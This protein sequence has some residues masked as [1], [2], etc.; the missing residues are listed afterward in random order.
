MFVSF[1]HR[2]L[3]VSSTICNTASW[4]PLLPPGGGTSPRVSL[5]F[6]CVFA[7][8]HRAGF[9]LQSISCLLRRSPRWLSHS[10]SFLASLRARRCP[11]QYCAGL[12]HPSSACDRS[13]RYVLILHVPAIVSAHPS[14]SRRVEFTPRVPLSFVRALSRR[15]R[16]SRDQPC[17][18]ILFSRSLSTTVALFALVLRSLRAFRGTPPSI[19][20]SLF[21]RL[22]VLHVVGLGL[23]LPD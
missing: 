12:V 14:T 19:S 5:S 6:V 21:P 18:L 23:S 8:R 20:L 2:A 13:P 4:P 16:H 7:R 11:R 17:I 22:V 9:A 1:L 15:P 3:L 10:L